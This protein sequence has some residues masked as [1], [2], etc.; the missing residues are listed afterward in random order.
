M[1]KEKKTDDLEQDENKEIETSQGE[2]LEEIDAPGWNAIDNELKKIYPDIEGI[3]YGNISPFGEER[4]KGITVYDI[5]GENPHWHF[6]TYG[7]T[8]LYGKEFEDTNR[9]GYGFELTFRLAKTDNDA[10]VPNWALNFLNNIANYIFKTG[11]VF[12]EGHY[13]NT[14]GPIEANSDTKIKAIVF[15]LDNKLDSTVETPNGKMKFLQMTGITLDELDAMITWNTEKVLN[16]LDLP[17]NITYMNRESKLTEKVREKIELGIEMEGSSTRFLYVD[18]AYMERDQR[19]ILF[20]G[21]LCI[22]N[23]KK[24]LKGVV[25]K[26]NTLT[27]YSDYKINFNISIENDV[28]IENNS[29]NIYLTEET[30]NEIIEKL[31][32]KAQVIVLDTFEGFDIVIE[33]SYVK[34]R[35]GNILE[36]VG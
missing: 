23:F 33:K 11:N 25:L 24:L 14:N 8:E 18:K 34:D 2:A 1:G 21:A 15:S 17:M 20:L 31:E 19:E 5:D 28:V 3:H 30:I 10:K 35:Y 9:S 16:L 7:L 12:S 29:Y 32:V 26:W 6:I 4:L 13:L 36:T 27:L 22:N